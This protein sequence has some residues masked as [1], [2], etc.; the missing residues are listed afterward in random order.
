MLN[1]PRSSDATIH[2]TPTPVKML[3]EEIG[4]VDTF[5][6]Q[7]F[8]VRGSEVKYYKTYPFDWR[9]FVV[10]DEGEDIYLG[11]SKARPDY[12]KIDALLEVGTRG[13]GRGA[14]CAGVT[15]IPTA[16]RFNPSFAR[17]APDVPLTCNPPRAGERSC[18][19]IRAGPGV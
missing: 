14:T 12:N 7:S 2:P 19:K 1:S 16:R 4:F 6:L 8:V 9:I 15:S 11:E 17:P 18:A 10:G 13:Q 5:S 3:D